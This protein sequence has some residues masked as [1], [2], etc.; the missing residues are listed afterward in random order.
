MSFI[1]HVKRSTGKQIQRWHNESVKMDGNSTETQRMTN[2]DQRIK[3]TGMA[4]DWECLSYS[5]PKQ[6][7]NDDDDDDDQHDE[8]AC[9][10]IQLLYTYSVEFKYYSKLYH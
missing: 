1:P 9:T 8:K 7:D 10:F 6:T 2:V 3:H 5:G 4:S